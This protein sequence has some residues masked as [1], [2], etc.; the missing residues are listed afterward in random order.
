MQ[1]LRTGAKIAVLTIL[2][3]AAIVALVAVG[4]QTEPGKKL[5]VSA[6]N[7]AMAG[8]AR[9][10][11]LGGAIPWDMTIAEIELQDPA[12]TW[13]R[14]E[15]AVFK[16]EPADLLRGRLT[17]ALLG[18]GKVRVDRKPEYASGQTSSGG[19]GTLP[20]AIDLQRLEAP[21]VELDS[22]VLGTTATLSLTGHVK[23]QN[24]EYIA[25]V[26][27]DRTDGE[28]GH[29]EGRFALTGDPPRLLVDV[30]VQEPRGTL[31]N[32]L[33]SRGDSLPLA[34]GFHGEG[35]LHDWHG[36]ME[37]RAGDLGRSATDVSI[38]KDGGYR[39]TLDGKLSAAQLLPPEIAAVVGDE[40]TFHIAAAQGANGGITADNVTLQAAAARIHGSVGVGAG[41]DGA[42]AADL[43]LDVEDLGKLS[44]LIGRPAA[45]SATLVLSG[46]GT[47]AKP[48]ITATLDG[49]GWR[50]A[51]TGVDGVTARIVA[52]TT[53]TLDD[54]SSRIRFSGSG[55]A[56]GIVAGAGFPV[57][58]QE[59]AWRI[60][61][62][63]SADGHALEITECVVD[64]LG[65]TLT[66]MGT[67][68]RDKRA[69][70]AK[71]HLAASDLSRFDG[72]A[73]RQIAGN[74]AIDVALSGE[75]PGSGEVK[76]SGGLR[77]LVTGIPIADA[78]LGGHV[79][80]DAA[81]S[82]SANGDVAVEDASVEA[83]HMRLVA[84]GRS[85]AAFDR[86]QGSFALEL[87]RLEVLSMEGRPVAGRARLEG[88][89][90][91]S[92]NA[93]QLDAVLTAEDV[94]SGEMHLDRLAA[95]LHATK[96][97]APTGAIDAD[98]KSGRLV[99]TLKG[100]GALSGDGKS[101]DL[102]TLK[103]AAGDTKV[104]A[105]LRTALDT[106]LTSGTIKAQ[107]AD[108]SQ[109]SGLVGI[110][111][112]GMLELDA[113]LTTEN[114]QSGDFSLSAKKV[115]LA[116]TT[117]ERIT[118]K[119]R[120]SDVFGAAGGN[121][122]LAILGAKFGAASLQ[123][124]HASVKSRRAGGITF[125]A[126]MRSEFKAPLE[127]ATAGD[128]T[129]SGST[130]AAR[131][132][133]FAAKLGDQPLR[134]DESLRITKSGEDVS[135]SGLKLALG[136]GEVSGAASLT[137]DNVLAKVIARDVPLALAEPFVGKGMVHGA[138]NADLDV[139]GAIESP[140]GRISM[141]AHGLRFATATRPDLPPI[142]VTAEARLQP[143]LVA[144][145]GRVAGPKG[146]TI[147][148]SGTVPIAVTQHP[149]SATVPR[150]GALS[151]QIKGDGQLE[152][153][154]DLLPIGED[155]LSGHYH[156]DLNASGTVASPSASGHVTLDHGHYESLLYGTVLDAMT[157]DL[158]GDRDKI[159][160]REFSATD[161]GKGT[162]KAG[163]TILLAANPG[164]VLDATLTL[165]AFQLVHR[166]NAIAHGSGDLRVAG[167]LAEPRV[168]ARLKVDDAQLFLAERLPPSVR[169]LDVTE[170]DSTT[171]E[172]L[173]QPPPPSNKPPIVAELDIKVDLPGQIF[174]RG[175]GLDSE[176]KG[177]FDVGGTSA[178]P[179]VQGGLEVVNGT[180]NFLGKTLDL[181]R[182]SVTLAGGNKI[183]PLLDFLAEST[184]AQI[185]A[186]VA[187]TGPAE[188]P[189]IKLTSE[190]PMPQDQVLAQLLF[191]RDVT[192]LTPME[193]LQIAQ[194]AAAL[195]SGGPGV[196]D[197]VRMK[198]GLDRLSIGSADQTRG[199]TAGS[200][201][202]TPSSTSR[203]AAGA[204]G[205]TTLSAGKY[206]APGVLVGVDQGVSGESRAKVEVEISRHVTVNT[207]A[208][209]DRGE[210]VG[211]TWKLDY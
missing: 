2:S 40:A 161:G 181:T 197:Q 203:S 14:V 57:P 170:I 50:L 88:T 44:S 180:M 36:R 125:A 72:L 34:I 145:V 5:L 178:A 98:F 132:T 142:D 82:R 86:T 141:T 60:S 32:R 96:E 112:S 199:T 122:D 114:G 73:G 84:K 3:I 150:N 152:N 6:V 89:L 53:A 54:P 17:V 130:I 106:R 153:L 99:G 149:F 20:V 175:R 92:A 9:V 182:G 48:S 64:G 101:L 66:A 47:R 52:S 115:G 193:G 22:P 162:L 67:A 95:R 196:I 104:D 168:T 121:G 29:L 37:A 103:F 33:L 148:L 100:R 76:I 13:G 201:S 195:A 123:Q 174:I 144:L 147:D 164:P 35:P 102:S 16:A 15:D 140:M 172:V 173:R 208:S 190:P 87:P 21:S 205:N 194:A 85:E 117:V 59:I 134:L 163:G 69:V 184:S 46:T 159:T 68:D 167:T 24:G 204:V 139:H 71:L 105:A 158:A 93:P 200:G 62:F 176:W 135:F 111:L 185:K 127:L 27:L 186:Q 51:D 118:G 61:G 10:S 209:A 126:D 171:G 83:A 160:L 91:G 138:V 109:L 189:S 70:V 94:R 38:S 154:A 188:N 97:P 133:K 26:A 202:S 108:L 43:R 41:A 155:R 75:A 124:L 42:F 128:A 116:G 136:S 191:G 8:Q 143:K 28:P 119:G 56:E 107:S 11:G 192:Q 177:H 131:I 45:G 25:L 183:E 78:L 63:S 79:A 179:D 7:H 23:A 165:N 58:G 151:M 30:D 49:Q 12:G 31:L 1:W 77:D 19:R 120:F 81:V 65:V 206:V 90:R 129:I 156:I 198:F 157:L 137:R 55:R 39:I 166:D 113:R 211:V 80:V 207:T 146:E 210:S 18:A 110:A 187:V 169:H 74:G 4:A